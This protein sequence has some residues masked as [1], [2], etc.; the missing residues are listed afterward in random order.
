M[1]P[2]PICKHPERI[3]PEL[4]QEVAEVCNQAYRLAFKRENKLPK[5]SNA[6]VVCVNAVSGYW[7]LECN[8][9][10]IAGDKLGHVLKILR[11]KVPMLRPASS[12]ESEGRNNGRV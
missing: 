12:N 1:R 3:T 2:L 8:D 10:E 7:S 4:A 9:P 11:A 6:P 5:P